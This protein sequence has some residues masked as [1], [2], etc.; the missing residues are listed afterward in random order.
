[1]PTRDELR[2]LSEFPA[3]SLSIEYE[4]WLNLEEN[5]GKANLAKAAIAV[6]N[7]G[8]GIIILG[9]RENVSEGGSLRSVIRPPSIPRYHPD[10]VNAAIARFCEPVFHCEVAFAESPIT[11]DLLP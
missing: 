2:A 6:A 7:E 9:M 1:M 8:G 4:S 11:G 3:E 5:A 10:D